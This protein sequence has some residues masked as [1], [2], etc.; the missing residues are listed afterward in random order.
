MSRARPRTIAEP[1]RHP[2]QAQDRPGDGRGP[3]AATPTG[4]R[5]GRPRPSRRIR[6]EVVGAARPLLAERTADLQRLQAEYANYRK[7]VERD[8]LAAGE[9]A[10]GRV[11]ADAAAGA[12]RHRP[13]PRRTAT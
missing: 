10:V 11:L 9:L 2:R 12:R 13:G 5:P 4:N 3:R 8:R 6:T 1:G 7:R